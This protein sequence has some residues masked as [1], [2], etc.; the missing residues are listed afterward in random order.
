MTIKSN[1]TRILSVRNR[2]NVIEQAN[3]YFSIL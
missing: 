3:I 1:R 2:T